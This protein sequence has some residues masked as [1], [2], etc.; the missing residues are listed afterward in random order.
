M[1][2]DN[3]IKNYGLILN[4]ITCIASPVECLSNIYKCLE[5][6]NL[7]SLTGFS[8][9]FFEGIANFLFAFLCNKMLGKVHVE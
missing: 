5:S 6:G 3:D 9:L 4:I 7:L 1:F 2:H 8:L